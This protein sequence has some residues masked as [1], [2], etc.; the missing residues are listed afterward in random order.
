M[1]ERNR[2][3]SRARPMSEDPPPGRTKAAD[4]RSAN[5]PDDELRQ[6]RDE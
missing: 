3:C 2:V 4:A 5:A 1:I 6:D